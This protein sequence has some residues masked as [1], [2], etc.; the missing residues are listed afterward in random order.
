MR[1]KSIQ[2]IEIFARR[3]IRADPVL[4]WSILG[5]F[6]TEH[7]WAS[8]LRSCRRNTDI[9]RIGTVRTCMLAKPLM[10]RSTVDEELIEFDPGKVL[11]YALRGSAGPFRSAQGRWTIGSVHGGAVVEIAGRFEPRSPMIGFLFGSL[12]RAA[13][14]RSAQRA[15]ADLATFVEPRSSMHAS[16]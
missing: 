9:V 14:M 1:K 11:S 15:L 13:A 10:G 12:A 4:V 7:R 3:V 8:Q 5:D 6:G 16:M 2:A